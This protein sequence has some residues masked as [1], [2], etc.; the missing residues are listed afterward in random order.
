MPSPL[1]TQLQPA[2]AIAK[3]PYNR[4][5]WKSVSG[6]LT[7]AQAGLPPYITFASVSLRCTHR[8]ILELIIAKA[9]SVNCE[10]APRVLSLLKYAER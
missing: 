8:P 4:V 10:F 3:C 1:A 2:C 9:E 5:V 7:D 6:F